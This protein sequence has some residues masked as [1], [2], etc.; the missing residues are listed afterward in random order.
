[1]DPTANSREQREIAVRILAR[2]AEAQSSSE[3]V[4]TNNPS[5]RQMKDGQRLA[6]LVL[7]VAADRGLSRPQPGAGVWSMTVKDFAQE[8]LGLISATIWTLLLLV[9][10]GGVLWAVIIIIAALFR[11]V[12]LE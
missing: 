4:I 2:A 3:S 6:E 9:A 10:V 5:L 11:T 8:M 7:G 12:V 1:M